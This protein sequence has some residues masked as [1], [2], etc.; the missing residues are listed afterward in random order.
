MHV[1]IEDTMDLHSFLPEE[2][3]IVVEEY[4]FQAMNKGLRDIRIIHGRGIGVQRQIVQSILGKN[5]NVAG[6]WD[7]DDRGS[8]LIRLKEAKKS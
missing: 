7:A 3:P 2:I 1:P 8:T 6:F 5:P 4:I